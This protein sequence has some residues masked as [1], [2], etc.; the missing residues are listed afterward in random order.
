MVLGFTF[1]TLRL[2]SDGLATAGWFYL[3]AAAATLFWI[4][5]RR[6]RIHSERKRR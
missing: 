1:G 6:Q 3:L 2:L 5:R 4:I